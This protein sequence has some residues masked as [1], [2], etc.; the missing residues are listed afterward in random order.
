MS[1]DRSF[2]ANNHNLMKT[3]L[4]SIKEEEEM[5][6][7]LKDIYKVKRHF[8]NLLLMIYIWI[9]SSF[10]LYLITFQLKYLPGSIYMNT[11]VSSFSD[12]PANLIGGL[13]YEKYGVRLTL[14]IFFVI[15]VAGSLCVIFLGGISDTI[16]AIFVMFT[17]VG[18]NTSFTL[19]YLANSGIFPAIF[20]GTAF[21]MCNVGAKFITIFAPMLAEVEKPVPMIIF[22]I[23]TSLAIF[24]SLMIKA[25]PNSAKH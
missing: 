1:E 5:K 18:V 25:P 24:A 19:C 10:G 20:A 3:P 4:Q 8:R 11:L 6:G 13:L 16:D 7:T 21:G 15:S 9:S 22:A 2:Q 17:R 14:P 23:V 12:I